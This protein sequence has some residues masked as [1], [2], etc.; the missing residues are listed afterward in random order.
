MLYY[1]R[2]KEK[3]GDLV[4]RPY[5]LALGTSHTRGECEDLPSGLVSDESHFVNNLGIDI[6]VLRL[7]KGGVENWQITDLLID[8][9]NDPISKN[10]QYIIAEL[11]GGNY[12]LHSGMDIRM[13]NVPLWDNIEDGIAFNHLD[14]PR[15]PE[16]IGRITQGD[17]TYIHELQSIMEAN[18]LYWETAIGTIRHF[19]DIR[20][21]YYLAKA[22]GLNF[23]WFTW[24]WGWDYNDSPPMKSLQQRMFSTY[25]EMFDDYIFPD[26]K[27]VKQYFLENRNDYY[28]NKCSCG[29]FNES[30]HRV[31][32]SVIGECL[33]AKRNKHVL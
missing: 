9:L 25:H 5:V 3:W 7:A 26:H 15:T 10:C 14:I 33:L 2:Q 30:G 28:S 6:P 4:N 17:N 29:H 27:S 20:S 24:L 31:L 23:Y 18:T 19:M 8:F 1:P 16:Q 22:H 21:Q 32:G 13:P 11:R 12:A